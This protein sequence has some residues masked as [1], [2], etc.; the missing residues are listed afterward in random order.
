MNPLRTGAVAGVLIII[1]TST[2]VALAQPPALDMRVADSSVE[3]GAPVR[4][5]GN[6]GRDLAGRTVQLEFAP[7][8]R[9]WSALA[10]AEIGADGRYSIRRALPRSGSLRVTVAPADGAAT[11]A[12]DAPS[13]NA[14]AVAVTQKVGIRVKRLNVKAGRSV[15][16]SGRVAPAAAGVPVSLQ[17]R[18]GGRWLPIDRARTSASGAFALSDRARRT[19]SAPVR[20][21]AGEKAGIARGK[22][23]V[24]RL[25]VF[26]VTHASWYGPGFYGQKTGCGGRL[27]F[28]QVGVAHKSLPCGTR[29]TFRYRGR[30]VVAPVID[31]GPYVGGREYD[32]TAVTAQ[33]LGF[34]GHGAILTTH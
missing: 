8:G 28:G 25:N 34:K 9:T 26:R 15:T 5:S 31:R 29:V 23:G 19:G 32:L 30:T 14:A 4:V 13:S 22:R 12:S 10:T 20:V 6:A 16:V 24:G 3:F 27:G 11:A 2:A 21:V 17:V 7:D 33:R 1:A 18:R